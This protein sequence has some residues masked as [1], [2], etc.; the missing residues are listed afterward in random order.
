MSFLKTVL[1]VIFMSTWGKNTMDVRLIGGQFNC[2]CQE[3]LNPILHIKINFDIEYLK[4]INIMHVNGT[5]SLMCHLMS[6]NLTT[7]F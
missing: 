4:T 1:P 3:F 6:F 2:R 7:I 5:L